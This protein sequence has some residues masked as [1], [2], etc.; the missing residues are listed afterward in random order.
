[1]VP[2]VDCDTIGVV[3]G[4]EAE[5]V[6]HRYRCGAFQRAWVWHYRPDRWPNVVGV[7]VLSPVHRQVVR[8]RR[9]GI[10]RTA[11]RTTILWSGKPLGCYLCYARRVIAGWNLGW[12]FRRAVQCSNGTGG[13]P[14]SIR[15]SASNLADA[16]CHTGFCTVTVQSPSVATQMYLSSP[17]FRSSTLCFDLADF[18]SESSPAALSS[19]GIPG[20]PG[21]PGVFGTYGH[22][23]GYEPVYETQP[24]VVTDVCRGCGLGGCGVTGARRCCCVFGYVNY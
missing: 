14:V 5:C 24:L 3:C 16:F 22:A 12:G 11:C 4:V 6:G 17:R 2:A 8:L 13:V 15:P 18:D 1:M 7:R 21:V 20:V 10:L 9:P 23:R 19:S